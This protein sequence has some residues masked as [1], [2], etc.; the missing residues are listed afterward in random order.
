MMILIDSA[1]LFDP[2]LILADLS[3]EISE[4]LQQFCELSLFDFIIFHL[5]LEGSVDIT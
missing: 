4:K 2:S 3:T 5:L 1:L